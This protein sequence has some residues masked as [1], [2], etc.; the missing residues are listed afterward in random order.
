MAACAHR[1]LDVVE[2]GPMAET[3]RATG[4][5]T[6]IGELRE[7]AQELGEIMRQQHRQAVVY[8]SLMTPAQRVKAA[9]MMAGCKG[10]G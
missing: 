9:R 6:Q 7:I 2:D 8:D 4:R 5:L 3:K 1:G 10:Q